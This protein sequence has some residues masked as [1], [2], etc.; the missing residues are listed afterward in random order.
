MSPLS[1]LPLPKH[2]AIGGHPVVY[3]IRA[4]DQECARTLRRRKQRP[5]A[6]R[7]G[8]ALKDN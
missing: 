1:A 8:T 3:G 6:R 2:R 4:S 5:G 7:L